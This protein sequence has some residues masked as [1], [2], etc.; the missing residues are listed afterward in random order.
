M[1]NKGK[2]SPPAS[3][4]HV[5]NRTQKWLQNTIVGL[6]LCPFADKPMREN[7]LS[8]Q[9]CRGKT[10]IEVAAVVI[11]ECERLKE[12]MG[13]AL[14]VTPDFY[15]D[16]FDEFW[17]FV[18]MIENELLE[19]YD[20]KEDI[21]VVPFHPLFQF[22]GNAEDDVDNYT[23]R[24]PYPL[25]HILREEE[26]GRAVDKIGGDAGKVWKRNINLLHKLD[27]AL[28]RDSVKRIIQGDTVE[29]IN[30]IIKNERSL[31]SKDDV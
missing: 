16:E 20:L 6:N 14:V 3:N 26:V 2:K 31:L 22:E 15:P 12:E 18:Q 11:K 5:K 23:N 10:Y 8:I 7:K 19:E 4:E 30:A 9:V 24:S 28:G 1:K 13:T 27:K 21:Q 17:E 29:G 25:I